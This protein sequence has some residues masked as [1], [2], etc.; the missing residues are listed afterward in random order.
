MEIHPVC[1][2][3]VARFAAEESGGAIAV[4]R[5]MQAFIGPGLAAV[6]RMLEHPRTGRFCHGDTPGLADICLAPQIYNARR[7]E[8]DL[9]AMPVLRR[10]AAALDDHPAVREAHPER[11]APAH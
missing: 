4:H 10:I 1:N 5:W 2:L 3:S 9:R 6:E 8:I 7:W 11:F